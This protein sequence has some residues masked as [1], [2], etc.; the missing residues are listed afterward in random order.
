MEL[1]SISGM[2]G[3]SK[4]V[5]YVAEANRNIAMLTAVDERIQK[6]KQE[7]MMLQELEAKQY[8]EI[9]A[10]A[11]TL[12]ERD[13]SAI[14]TRSLAL[15]A[16]IT[17]KIKE[18]GSRKRFFASGG[19]ALLLKYKSD[20]LNSPEMIRYESNKKN[21]EKLMMLQEAGKGAFI[22][23]RDQLSLERYNSGESNEITYSG[24]KSE[25]DLPEK[26]YQFGQ[27]LA[28]IQILEYGDNYMRI[29][30]N[31]LKDHPEFK[32]L[33]GNELRTQ[34]LEYTAQNYGGQGM[35][36]TLL[37][38]EL[39]LNRLR[40]SKKEIAEKGTEK[41]D[42]DVPYITNVNNL[43]NN[44]DSDIETTKENIIGGPSYIE[45][46]R[47]QNAG[48]NA[49]LGDKNNAYNEA[50]GEIELGGAGQVFR[51]AGLKMSRMF[52][53]NNTYAPASA[54][55]ILPLNKK[56]LN[57]RLFTAQNPDGT[58][59]VTIN[60]SDFYNPN[61]EK[62]QENQIET[63]LQNSGKVSIVNYFLG[64][65]DDNGKLMTNVLDSKGKPYMKN[66]KIDEEIVNDH[67]NGFSGKGKHNLF[68]ALKDGDGR[69]FYQRFNMNDLQGDTVISN[70]L[71]ANNNLSRT[72]KA[73]KKYDNAKQ[74]A[75]AE[76]QLNSNAI[77]DEVNK[78]SLGK[79]GA[80]TN[81]NFINEAAVYKSNDG[82]DRTLMIKAYYMM[83]SHFKTGNRMSAK[84]LSQNG[85]ID[86]RQFTSQIKKYSKLENNIFKYKEYND[87]QFID[88]FA[89]EV[90]EGKSFDLA[91]NQMIANKWKEFYR[92]IKSQQ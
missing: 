68:V 21:M 5:D 49:L 17:S 33:Q 27:K 4:S 25:V 41:Q 79:K 92:I 8:E 78:A 1:G 61:G 29:L 43:L 62:I 37:E 81:P 59:N 64:W 83:M 48:V 52:G 31:M 89:T 12:L 88:L 75:A 36:K 51:N 38:H 69:V 60:T 91:K 28:P 20:L 16:D 57:E 86:Q 45:K 56:E 14:N 85:L 65:E 71:G 80:F 84:N 7:S 35:D 42:E 30:G 10:R 87:E 58:V 77:M 6:E 46:L 47:T 76:A 63:F 54:V 15:Q 40:S 2:L 18:Y 23:K 44:A 26:Y 82:Q 72:V 19:V 39:A 66:G 32:G 11:A 53:M 24:L 67:R 22:T 73:T 3:L 34:L 55:K 70:A 90:S 50:Y 13:R 74:Q 9:S